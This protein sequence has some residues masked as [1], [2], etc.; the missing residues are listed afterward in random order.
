MCS[1]RLLLLSLLFHLIFRVSRASDID[2][3]KKKRLQNLSKAELAAIEQQQ[4]YQRWIQ[5]ARKMDLSDIARLGII[6]ESGTAYFAW[7][8]F[9]SVLLVVSFSASFQARMCMAVP[10]L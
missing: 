1:R 8:P 7:R 9:L 10:S 2:E 6:Y 4:T 3:E 5:Q